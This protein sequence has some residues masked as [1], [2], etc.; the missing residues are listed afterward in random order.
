[1]GWGLHTK[2]PGLGEIAVLGGLL[3]GYT[4]IVVTLARY[5]LRGEEAGWW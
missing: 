4:G 1:M 3:V 2:D 5:Y